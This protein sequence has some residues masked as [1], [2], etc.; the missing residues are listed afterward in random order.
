MVTVATNP[1][2]ITGTPYPAG[3]SNPNPAYS[4]IFIP[5]IWTGKLIEKFY[6]ATVLAAI[7]NTDYSGEIASQGDTVIIRTKPTISINSYDANQ[8]LVV[9]RPSSNIVELN[10]DKGIYFNTI[11][12]D[13]METQADLN[14][15]S[16]WSDDASITKH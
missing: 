3:S 7:A 12:D 4:N 14:L 16:M 2:P 15:L 6:D 8:A 10:I 5:A 13:V 9:E 11:L 1:Y